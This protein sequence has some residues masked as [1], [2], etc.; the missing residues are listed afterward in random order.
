MVYCETVVQVKALH[1]HRHCHVVKVLGANIK[2][3]W[4]SIEFEIALEAT[5]LFLLEFFL[6]A[7][8]EVLSRDVLFTPWFDPQVVSLFIKSVLV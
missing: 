5:A 8:S 3:T 6:C 7:C 1:F 4:Y 2:V